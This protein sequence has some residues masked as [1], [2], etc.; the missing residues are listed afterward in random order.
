MYPMKKYLIAT[1]ILLSNFFIFE[2]LIP[3][4][5]V[6]D[7]NSIEKVSFD[8]WW[9]DK[10]ND[11]IITL[12][13]YPEDIKT[14]QVGNGRFINKNQVLEIYK[15]VNKGSIFSASSY[16]FNIV[17]KDENSKV[18]TGKIIFSNKRVSNKF[19]KAL[20]DFGF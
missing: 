17:Y 2:P 13:T 15:E 11:S 10:Y 19:E 3:K 9:E 5:I 7:K 8:I 20:I 4:E 12:R 16:I 6:E 14:I 18:S 1:L